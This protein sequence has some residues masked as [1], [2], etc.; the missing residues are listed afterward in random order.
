M[1]MFMRLI[2]VMISWVY[3]HLQ[4]CEVVYIKYVQLFVCQSKNKKV[5]FNKVFF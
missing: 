3:A 2:M 4:T 5:Y 1:G